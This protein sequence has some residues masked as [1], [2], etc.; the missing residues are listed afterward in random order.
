MQINTMLIRRKVL[1]PQKR[2]EKKKKQVGSKPGMQE[3][4][5]NAN[6]Y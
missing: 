3:G 1:G 5:Q 6:I 2:K 4:V